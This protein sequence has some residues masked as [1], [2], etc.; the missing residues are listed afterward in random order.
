[1]EE[2]FICD[3]EDFG[4]CMLCVARAAVAA[5]PEDKSFGF[6]SWIKIIEDNNQDIHSSALITI[7]GCIVR[8]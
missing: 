5:V 6:N 2:L 1:M 3:S 8:I 7:Y 4:G